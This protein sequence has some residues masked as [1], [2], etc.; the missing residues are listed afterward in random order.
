MDSWLWQQG[1]RLG[2][3]H[4]HPSTPPL[5]T[6]QT[7]LLA[8]AASAVGGL[9]SEGTYQW[10][11]LHTKNDGCKLKCFWGAELINYYLNEIQNRV[12]Q[13]QPIAVAEHCAQ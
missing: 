11:Q 6:V 4:L 9:D 3:V 7:P 12:S 8:E 1:C 13:Q 10:V 5:V 2:Q